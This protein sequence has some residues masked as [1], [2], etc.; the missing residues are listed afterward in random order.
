M[1]DSKDRPGM[2]SF[3]AVG[4]IRQMIRN[5]LRGNKS[6]GAKTRFLNDAVF[7]KCG[8]KYPALAKQYQKLRH[9]DDTKA[10]INGK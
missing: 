5:E 2:Q 6:R 8:L 1:K 10:E 9:A 3:E 4:P 7:A